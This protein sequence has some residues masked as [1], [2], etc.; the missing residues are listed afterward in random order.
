[1]IVKGSLQREKS[2]SWERSLRMQELTGP[3]YLRKNSSKSQPHPFPPAPVT[4]AIPWTPVPIS[5]IEQ[6]PNWGLNHQ[7]PKQVKRQTSLLFI[8][9]P[10]PPAPQTPTILPP[11]LPLHPPPPPCPWSPHLTVASRSSVL[12]RRCSR[13]SPRARIR[14]TFWVIIFLTP[15]TSLC[16]FL[17]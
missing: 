5:G 11:S 17:T 6:N 2:V 3:S 12:L 13:F 14:S 7:F 10:T 15:S 4:G 1:M 9:P 8:L 16:R